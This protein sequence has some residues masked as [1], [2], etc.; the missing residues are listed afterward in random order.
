MK[1]LYLFFH[2]VEIKQLKPQYFNM[3]S[4]KRLIKKWVLLKLQTNAKLLKK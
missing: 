4:G 1:K 3:F 2:H